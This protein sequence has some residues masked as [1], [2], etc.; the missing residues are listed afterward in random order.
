MRQINP[1]NSREKL[2]ENQTKFKNETEKWLEGLFNKK[3]S[4]EFVQN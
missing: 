1:N 4:I 3:I 2:T